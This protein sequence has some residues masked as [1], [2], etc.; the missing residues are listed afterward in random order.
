MMHIGAM[1]AGKTPAL[2]VTLAQLDAAG[3]PFEESDNGHG[4]TTISTRPP[5]AESPEE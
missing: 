5:G 3:V 4:T 1:G 2:A